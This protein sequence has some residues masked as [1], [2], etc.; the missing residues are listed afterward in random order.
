MTASVT[1]ADLL[2]PPSKPLGQR[3]FD[4][5]LWGGIAVLLVI[6]FGPAEMVKLPL[7]FE[8]WTTC[9][10]SGASSCIPISA[11]GRSWSARCG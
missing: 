3:L 2:K 6:S 4:I 7:L 10:S 9:A 1:L 8:H 5:G 11:T